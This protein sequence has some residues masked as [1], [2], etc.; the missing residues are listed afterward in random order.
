MIAK[1]SSSTV[2]YL[3]C[4]GE[5]EALPHWMSANL[6]LYTCTSAKPMPCSLEALVRTTVFTLGSNGCSVVGDVRAFL[7][8]SK[9]RLCSGSHTHGV[10]F[11]SSC[12]R[13]L[14][15]H[16]VSGANAP[17]WATKPWKERDDVSCELDAISHLEF[18]PRNCYVVVHT[19]SLIHI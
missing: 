12:R 8:F 13:W 6:S 1:H 11:C 2:Q 14:V 3:D 18:L 17:N 10:S 7:V 4:V 19:L 15:R 5:S 16:A 9:S